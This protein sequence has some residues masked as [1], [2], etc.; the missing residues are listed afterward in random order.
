V[1]TK[2]YSTVFYAAEPAAFVGDRSAIDQRRSADPAS[3][4]LGPATATVRLFGDR[5]DLEALGLPAAA[6]T[7]LA[8]QDQ[9]ELWRVSLASLPT[10]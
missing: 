6:I 2:R 4:G 5:P 7:R 8:R 9:Q 10:R 3:L 1:G